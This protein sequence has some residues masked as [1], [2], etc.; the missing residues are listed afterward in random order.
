MTS[1][2]KLIA[3]CGLDCGACEARKATLTNDDE[4]RKEVSRKWCQMNGTD[5][6]TPETINCEGCR[7]GGVKFAYCDYMCPIRKC[8]LSKG[9]DTCADCPEKESCDMLA[10]FTSN[11]EAR[12]NLGL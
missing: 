4:L 5:Q 8:A 3:Y 11:D 7:T 2:N 9:I 6:I 1:D 10:P 12:S